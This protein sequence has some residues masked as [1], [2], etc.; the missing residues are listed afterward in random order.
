MQEKRKHKRFGG[1]AAKI[2]GKMILA[3]KVDIVD[4]SADGVALKADRRLEMGK[5]YRIQLEYEGNSLNVK[6]VVVRSSLSGN[7]MG[8]K[9]GSAPTY[10]AGLMFQE[11]IIE[12]VAHFL[13][14]IKLG[15]K[16][17]TP[18]K[19]DRRRNVR[20]YI[21][22]SGDAV[23]NYPVDYKVIQ[24]SLRGMLIQTDH[25][26]EK[27][28]IVP[29]EMSLH[30]RD[31]IAFKGRVALC[32]DFDD[33]GG[34]HYAIGMEFLDLSDGDRKVLKSFIDYLAAMEANT[35]DNISGSEDR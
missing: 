21:T 23:L 24:I 9:A 6:G 8:E 28:S 25:T 11:S 7:E 10:R 15:N 17:K 35:P 33:A 34:T 27:E 16:E 14:A 31:T 2:R 20:F 13:G 12:E 4:I 19:T 29:I 26:I 3:K 30:E 1:D 22:T 18:V 32:R 5:E